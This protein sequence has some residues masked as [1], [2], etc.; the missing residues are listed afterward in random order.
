[1]IELRGIRKRYGPVTALAGVDV[2]VLP[3]E[4][5][6]IVGPN[7]A[8]KTTL[9]KVLLGLVR[10]DAGELRMDGAPFRPDPAFRR[11]VGYMPQTAAFPGN[12][13]GEEVLALLA[14]LRPGTAPDLAL[15]DALRLGPDLR[16]PI[17]VLS[18]GT[19]QKLSGVV[20]F[21]FAPELLVLDEPT[22]GLDPLAATVLKDLILAER[23]RGRMLLISS[24]VMAE[25]EELCDRVLFLSEGRTRFAGA[26]SELNGSTGQ[27]TLERAI[28]ALMTADEV[29]S[30]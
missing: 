27:V 15:V 6:G 23:S 26:V 13:S 22:A 21:A 20:A 2:A 24:H 30:P 3:G 5:V 28:A 4:V 10:A 29:P 12:L 17:G 25:L 8:G 1:M 18:E 9:L 11:R 14:A 7:G 19:R 16:R